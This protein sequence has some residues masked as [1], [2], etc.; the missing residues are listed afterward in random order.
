MSS[1]DIR[2]STRIQSIIID[3][4]IEPSGIFIFLSTA[5]AKSA[6]VTNEGILNSCA[7]FQ[8]KAVAEPITLAS[9]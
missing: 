3:L 8:V 5:S 7:M 1:G 6:K 4:F 2:M 9:N